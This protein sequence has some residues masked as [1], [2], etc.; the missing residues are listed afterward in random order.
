MIP[1]YVDSEI[2]ESEYFIF[3]PAIPTKSLRLKTSD[4]KKVYENIK[5]P[6]K[7]FKSERLIVV[8]CKV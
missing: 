7:F 3:N 4:F 1:V 2:F 6:V 8:F 5:N